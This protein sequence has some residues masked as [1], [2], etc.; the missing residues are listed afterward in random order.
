MPRPS[1]PPTTAR[2]NT[3]SRAIRG[4][5]GRASDPGRGP[6]RPP[7][8]SSRGLRCPLR[9]PPRARSKRSSAG[10]A[11][12]MD[13]P[14]NQRTGSASADAAGI[15][16]RRSVRAP[17]ADEERRERQAQDQR[18]RDIR[19]R[20]R[21]PGHREDPVHDPLLPEP[22]VN[23]EGCRDEDGRHAEG[24]PEVPPL[25]SDREPDEAD[26]GCHLRQEDERPR[27]RVAEAKD[28]RGGEEQVDVAVV[29]LHGNRRK[30]EDEKR[31]AASRASRP[32]RAGRPST[33][34]RTPATTAGSPARTAVR[35]PACTGK[36]PSSP[37]TC[38]YGCSRFTL[39]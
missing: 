23:R 19:L 30:R 37:A 33:Q 15:V 31:A 4:P 16:Q 9:R 5:R 22:G 27:R 10:I 32:S 18:D 12:R 35:R 6:A 34:T 11:T 39:Q 8:S 36:A 13:R 24:D 3:P 25:P 26:A 28:D 1:H 21:L 14:A 7:G 2:A 38:R 29:E 17:H 20:H